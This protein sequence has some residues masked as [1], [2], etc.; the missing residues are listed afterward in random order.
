[1]CVPLNPNKL[2]LKTSA[3]AGK[4]YLFELESDTQT[5]VSKLLITKKRYI[6]YNFKFKDKDV[7]PLFTLYHTVLPP[8]A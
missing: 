7:I 3:G 8:D 1:M 2:H 6:A 4:K 5:N